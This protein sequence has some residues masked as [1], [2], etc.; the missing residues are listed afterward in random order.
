MAKILIIG[1]KGMLGQELVSVFKSDKDY[2]VIAWDKEDL[3][4]TNEV[5]VHK[6]IKVINPQIIINAAAYNAVDKCEDSKEYKI[7]QKINGLAPGYLAKI[8]KKLKATLIHYS[9]DYV[10]DGFPEIE[11]PKGCAHSCGNCQ[12]H[13]KPALNSGYSENSKPKPI[14]KYG[15]TKLLG[16]IEVQKN[17]K[18]YY[19]IRTSKIFGKPAKAEGAKKSF[20]DVMLEMGK[21]QKEVRVIDSEISCF[22]YAPDLAKKTKEIIESKKPFGI[23]HVTNSGACAWHEAAVELY[24]LK[25]I[26]TKVIPISSKELERPAK[27]PAISVLINTKLNPLRNWKEALKEYLSRTNSK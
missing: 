1:A 7:A 14:N 6:K 21:K 8:A 27:R 12:L 22:T 2:R 20:F 23:Y 9:S 25:K 26:K 16:E 24:K 15:K 10:F 5:A 11:E 4:I 3:D 17:T 13:N 19:V 18:K